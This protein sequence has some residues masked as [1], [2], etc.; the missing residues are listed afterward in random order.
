MILN[1]YFALV[2][3][4]IPWECSFLILWFRLPELHLHSVVG[5][6]NA[7]VT[8]FKGEHKLQVLRMMLPQIASQLVW[9][10]PFIFWIIFSITPP[11]AHSYYTVKMF[12]SR[13]YSVM[14]L[15]SIFV[16]C[17]RNTTTIAIPMSTGIAIMIHIVGT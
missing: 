2:W 11:I 8:G 6:Q 4:Q 7:P 1:G 16:S 5:G 9:L 13:F 10:Q 17:L 3:T 15:F 12:F 14:K